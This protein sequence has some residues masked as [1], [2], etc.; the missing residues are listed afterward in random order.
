MLVRYPRGYAPPEDFKKIPHLGTTEDHP[1]GQVLWSGDPDVAGSRTGVYI[2]LEL[3]GN[4][5]QC[6]LTVAAVA[7]KM[8]VDA[9]F[10]AIDARVKQWRCDKFPGYVCHSFVRNG[11]IEFLSDCSHHLAGK[12][13]PLED[14]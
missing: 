2:P 12:I 3:I 6:E 8:G 5:T 14:D 9:T 4:D 1:H 13:V 7:A 11:K 10:D